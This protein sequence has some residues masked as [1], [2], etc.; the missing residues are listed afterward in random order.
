MAE[1]GVNRVNTISFDENQGRILD[2]VP[3][4]VEMAGE[5]GITVTVESCPL[6]PIAT[7]QQALALIEH[8][9]LPNFKLLIDTMHVVRNDEVE[10]LL[11]LDPALIDYVQISDGP[12]KALTLI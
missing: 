8:A 3:K 6:L 9:A 5:F 1:I 2:E 4:L 11:S 12:V 7:L 10:L